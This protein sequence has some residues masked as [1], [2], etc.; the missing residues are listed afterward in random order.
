MQTIGGRMKYYEIKV[1]CGHVGKN[2]YYVGTL[3]LYGENGR[4]AAAYARRHPRVKHDHK[5]A[6]FCV[7]EISHEAYLK[8]KSDTRKSVYWTSTCIQQQRMFC[9]E[10]ENQI[11]QE[12]SKKNQ[13]RKN[14]S[15]RKNYNAFDP[16]YSE[17]SRYHGSI[18][19]AVL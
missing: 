13:Y 4:E 11:L 7:K 19:A 15:L 12:D 18:E 14:H 9:P 2:N 6:I 3:Y 10:L 8:G 16:M 1:K 5:D 17:Y